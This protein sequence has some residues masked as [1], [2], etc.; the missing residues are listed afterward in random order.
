MSDQA[1]KIGIIGCGGISRAHAGGYKSAEGAE[2]VAVS[3]VRPGAAEAMAGDQGAAFYDDWRKMIS[4]EKLD[5]V[6]ICTP[7]SSHREIALGCVEAGLAVLCEKPLADSVPAAAEIE[8][9]ARSSGKPFMVGFK[10]RFH[11]GVERAKELLEAGELGEV[12][13]MRTMAAGFTDMSDRWFSKRAIAGGGVALDN[14]VHLLDTVRFVAGDIADI[15]AR[16]STIAQEMEVENT[17]AFLFSLERGGY[18]TAMLSWISATMGDWLGEL[19]GTKGSVFWDWASF[20]HRPKDGERACVEYSPEECNMFEREVA[21]FLDCVRTGAT[22]RATAEDGLRV[23]Q[24][25]EAA[26]RSADD[27][28][29]VRPGRGGR[30]G[31][32]G[33]GRPNAEARRYRRVDYQGPLRPPHGACRRGRAQPPRARPRRPRRERRAHRR[34]AA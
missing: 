24:V 25:I 28:I 16:A 8:Q 9:A 7:P 3:D 4:C 30:G 31:G 33:G 26:Y 17:A 23:Q 1:L 20:E 18:G 13:L 12:V 21:H 27:E 10:F 34:A 32:G 15:S 22:P 11:P 19:H 2:I 6:S 14:G 5:A 29:V